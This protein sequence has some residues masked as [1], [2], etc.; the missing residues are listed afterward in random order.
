M[1][2]TLRIGGIGLHLCFNGYVPKHPHLIFVC[3]I[4]TVVACPLRRCFVCPPSYQV[5]WSCALH[6]IIV[7]K[8]FAFVVHICI[9][10]G[11]V[12]CALS[13]GNLFRKAVFGTYLFF[14]I[15]CNQ[16]NSHPSVHR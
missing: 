1:S 5:R 11:A 10:L 3:L 9:D 8:G 2:R 6:G 16:P 7:G 15:S 12:K 13:F 14:E 4:T